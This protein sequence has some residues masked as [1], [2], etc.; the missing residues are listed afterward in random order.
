[1]NVPPE[2]L[3]CLD[4]VQ[5]CLA[6]LGVN[7]PAS[8]FTLNGKPGTQ[9]GRQEGMEARKRAAVS[10]EAGA[11]LDDPS[12]LKKYDKTEEQKA[13]IA[14]AINRLP[15]FSVLSAELKNQVIDAFFEKKASKEENIIVQGD[16]GDNFYIVAS[17]D[18][19]VLLKQKGRTPVHF[20]KAGDSFGELALMYN[21]PRAA[22]VQCISNGTLWA[23][24]R[25][26]FRLVQMQSNKTAEASLAQVRASPRCV[27]R[28]RIADIPAAIPS[29]RGNRLRTCER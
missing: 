29:Q 19:C 6:S 27:R 17:G 16:M 8:R 28:C 25:E 23:L 18:Y 15:S 21:T 10:A 13:A 20:Y 24:D 9:R 5:P 22:T 26:S 12:K 14:H 1:M 11:I 4:P 7:F 3:S 2:L